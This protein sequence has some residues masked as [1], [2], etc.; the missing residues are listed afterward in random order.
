[1]EEITYQKSYQE[2]KAELDGELQKTAEGFVRIGY[3][4]KVAR[5]T[6]ILAESGY[7]TV[8]EFAEAEY[9]LNKT[10]V[11][12]FISIN[13]RFSEEGYSDRLKDSYKDFGYAKLTIMLQL[14][15]AMTE[16]LSPDYSKAEIQ[17]LK[18]EMDEE[19][20]ISDI[21][22][23]IE[24]ADAEEQ[25]ILPPEEGSML[26]KAVWQLGKEQQEIY[27]KVWKAFEEGDRSRVKDILAP[28]GDAIYMMRIQGTGRL[29]LSISGEA[30]SITEVRSQNKERFSVEDII[31]ELE[32]ICPV[33]GMD[34]K[35]AY[36][37]VYGEDLEPQE[38]QEKKEEVAPVQPIKE[39]RKESKVTKARTEK[40]KPAAVVE[41]EQREEE[42][43][44]GQMEVAD[45]EGIVPEATYEEVTEDGRTG[46]DNIAGVSEG[47]GAAGDA[48]GH[49]AAE[50]ASGETEDETD[51]EH[52]ESHGTAEGE[53]CGEDPR[54][55]EDIWMDI[56]KNNAELTKYL[57]VWESQR[58]LMEKEMLKKL[59]DMTVNMAA[60]FERLLNRGTENE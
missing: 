29:M 43:L 46:I 59:Y 40:P 52:D 28:Q 35:E 13:D 47:S 5:D 32:R 50:T 49:G 45:Y 57:T 51:I 18:E 54:G 58:S 10:Q 33:A 30:V 31:S 20:K 42:Q 7:Q 23:A 44:P 26:G 21:E 60:G 53:G 24:K 48:L 15:E 27:R 9:N 12:R 17:E 14:P 56:Y 22:L 16:E 19:K 34:V 8:T 36:R 39:K 55:V 41:E 1:M 6:N 2:Y 25:R 3:L 38:K 37:S 11:S 4:L